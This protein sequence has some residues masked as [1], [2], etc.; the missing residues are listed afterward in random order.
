MKAIAVHTIFI[1]IT[2]VL[3]F[4]FAVIIIFGFL[5]I[6]AKEANQATCNVKLISYCTN[7]AAK[8]YSDSDKPYD[9]GY[10]SPT[11]CSQY[12]KDISDASGPTKEQCKPTVK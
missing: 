6:G 5:H 10:K 11:G 4:F 1:I 9:W 2:T 8:G 7:W 3:F 12:L